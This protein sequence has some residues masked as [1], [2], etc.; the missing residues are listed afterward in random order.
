VRTIDDITGD[1]EKRVSEHLAAHAGIDGKWIADGTA[2]AAG[3]TCPYCGQSV[4]GL[5]LVAAYRV[6][7]GEGYKGLKADIRWMNDSIH[8]LFG[9]AAIGKLIAPHHSGAS[10]LPGES[11]RGPGKISKNC[12][13][14]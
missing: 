2:H 9:E 12:C 14:R 8:Q 13:V 5:P 1:A 10:V 7:F 11:G 4:E 3:D 6:F